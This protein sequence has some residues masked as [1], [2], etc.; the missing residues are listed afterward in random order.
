MAC[1]QPLPRRE[2]GRSESR[3]EKHLAALRDGDGTAGLIEVPELVLEPLRDVA[4]RGGEPGRHVIGLLRASVIRRFGCR[5][6][7]N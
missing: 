2:I 5:A 3:I 6:R 7:E 4:K 1:R